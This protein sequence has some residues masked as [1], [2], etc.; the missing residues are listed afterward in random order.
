M[1]KFIHLDNFFCTE[2]EHSKAF[3][4]HNGIANCWMLKLSFVM[5]PNAGDDESLTWLLLFQF[6]LKWTGNVAWCIVRM[7]ILRDLFPGQRHL[8]ETHSSCDFL[9][10]LT[11]EVC[12]VAFSCN[13]T[14]TL[15][16]NNSGKTCSLKKGM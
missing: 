8:S 7:L 4:D 5:F 3:F 13:R 16:Y 15:Y 10:A 11:V 14:I 6:H 1:L 9:V 2:V 12:L